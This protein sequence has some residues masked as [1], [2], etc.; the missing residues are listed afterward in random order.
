MSLRLYV[1]RHGATEWSRSGQHTGRSDI[2]LTDVGR[3]EAKGI[4]ARIQK[5]EFS[6]VFVSPL[7]RAKDTCDLAGL[8]RQARIEDDLI[9]WDNG[10]YEGRTA[11]EIRESRAG[12]NVFRDGCPNGESPEQITMRADRLIDSL[13]KMQGNVALF[14]HGH[15][16]RSFAARWIGQKVEFAQ[17]LLLDTASVSVLCHHRDNPEQPAILL[18]NSSSFELSDDLSNPAQPGQTEKPDAAPQPIDRWEN[19]GGE[20]PFHGVALSSI[21]TDKG[22]QTHLVEA[23][24]EAGQSPEKTST[25]PPVR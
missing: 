18:W 11:K 15:F 19:E 25:A 14:T 10:D 12:W 5:I 20:I 2:E 1:I 7:R 22:G 21:P 6:E 9:E 17:Y 3:A 4:A 13:K 24:E 23:Y 16:G 8:E